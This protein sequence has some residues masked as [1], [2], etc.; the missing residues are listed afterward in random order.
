MIDHQKRLQAAC[1]RFAFE[2][3]KSL[4]MFWLIQKIPCLY[5]KQPWKRLYERTN[6]KN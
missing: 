3:S 6:N 1:R 4:G 2:F 5:I